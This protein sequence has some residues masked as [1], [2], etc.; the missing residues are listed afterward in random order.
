MHNLK[1]IISLIFLYHLTS[2][3]KE[4]NNTIPVVE[5]INCTNQQE[6]GIY[7]PAFPKSWWNYLDKNNDTVRYEISNTYEDCEGKCRPIFLNL[8]KCI[9]GN[10]LMQSFYAG[11]GTSA[12]IES[13]IY[14]TIRDSV[15]VCPIS[16]STFKQINAFLGQEDVPYR[17]NTNN[18]DTNITVNGINYINVI[19]VY[20]Y[21]KFDSSHRYYDYFSRNIGLIKRDS[22]NINDT[23]DLIEILRLQNYH[24]EN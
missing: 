22:V 2:C 10:S 15:L 20:E 7:F 21:N 11:L 17:R 6:P 8:N 24:I 16:F 9:Q 19:I 12:T 1:I 3:S 13:P 5:T 23:T 18:V 14:S 4:E